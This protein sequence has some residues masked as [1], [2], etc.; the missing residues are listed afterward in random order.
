MQSKETSPFPCTMKFT[1]SGFIS[2]RDICAILTSRCFIC[3]IPIEPFF[4]SGSG[5]LQVTACDCLL[6]N[7]YIANSW[8]LYDNNSAKKKS[9]SPQAFLWQLI[10]ASWISSQQGSMISLSRRTALWWNESWWHCLNNSGNFANHFAV[11]CPNL[12]LQLDYVRN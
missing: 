6:D 3:L 12:F 1:F 4:S 7:T 5:N 8:C 2:S 10:L 9:S 11:I